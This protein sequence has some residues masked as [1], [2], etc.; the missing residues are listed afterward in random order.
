L[1]SLI[2]LKPAVTFSLSIYSQEIILYL[3]VSPPTITTGGQGTVS[4]NVTGYGGNTSGLEYE[5]SMSDGI[6]YEDNGNTMTFTAPDNPGAITIEVTI[7]DESGLDATGSIQVTVAQSVQQ[8]QTQDTPS[9]G[10]IAT[11]AQK[12]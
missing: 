11:D 5:W 12:K 1:V 8:G 10:V 9:E 3:T 2:S 4:V 6:I 7:S